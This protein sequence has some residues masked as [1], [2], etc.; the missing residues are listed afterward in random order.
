M[1][2]ADGLREVRP[3]DSQAPVYAH[4]GDNKDASVHVDTTKVVDALADVF[5]KEPALKDEEEDEER[6]EEQDN[7]VSQG[8]I[9]DKE[10]GDG[11]TAGLHF[12]QD[13]PNDKKIS[14]Q[15][16]ESS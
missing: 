1:L 7:A 11:A 4:E 14:W 10:A 16:N 15:A 6:R 3:V 12:P 5:S 9:E 13:T 8:Q 2:L